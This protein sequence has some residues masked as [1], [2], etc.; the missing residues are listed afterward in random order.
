MKEVALLVPNQM[1]S[2][3][4]IPENNTEF[5]VSISTSLATTETHLT[6]E[7][8]QECVDGFNKSNQ[9][10]RILCLDYLSPWLKN[11][12][13]FCCGGDRDVGLAKIMDILRLLINLTLDRPEVR[14]SIALRGC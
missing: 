5:I 1:P 4:C 11:L 8:I 13:L 2:D 14:P 7:F 12:A 3:L 6:F 10:L 9:K